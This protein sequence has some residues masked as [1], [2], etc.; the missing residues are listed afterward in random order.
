MERQF[1]DIDTVQAQEVIICTKARR[2]KGV[3][4]DPIRVI[5]EVFTKDG[6]LIAEHDPSPNTFTADEVLR[7]ARYAQDIPRLTVDDLMS[8]V[9]NGKPEPG[10]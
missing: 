6:Q 2:G 7:F 3:T 1:F 8:W 10:L 4:L 5:T 9:V